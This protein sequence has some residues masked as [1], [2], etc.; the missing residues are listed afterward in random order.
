MT[1]R[2]A[3]G[4]SSRIARAF[5]FTLLTLLAIVVAAIAFFPFE[6]LAPALAA[7]IEAET[8]IAATIEALDARLGS[9]GP[10]LEASGV[11]LR[12]PTGETLA[13]DSLRVRAARPLSWLRGVPAAYVEVRAAFG[14]CDGTISRDA[15]AGTLAAFDLSALPAAWF[16]EQGA[17][18][19]G[20]VDAAFE[21]TKLAGQWSGT[22][23]LAGREGSLQPP[24]SPIAIPYETLTSAL[25]LD[26]VGTLHLDALAL[27]GPMVSAS[28]KGEVAAGYA[29]P[30]SGAISIEAEIARLDPTLAP[31]LA[32]YGIALDPAGAGRVQVAGIPDAIEVRAR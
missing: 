11:S 1:R 22:L 2:G 21:L 12:W 20:P 29:G 30:A 27:E 15:L 4:A 14:A 26:A 10:Q 8:R 16:G 7:R 28:A 18:L 9:R 3:R 19:A 25:R 17:P 31:A 6:R 32:A 23:E 13:L 5:A 24:G